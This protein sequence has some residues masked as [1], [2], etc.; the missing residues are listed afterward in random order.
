MSTA[1]PVDSYASFALHGNSTIYLTMNWVDDTGNPIDPDSGTQTLAIKDSHGNII[2]SLASNQITRIS[3]GSY[4]YI[5]VIPVLTA[6][7][8]YCAEWYAS[9]DAYPDTR[10][11][12]FPILA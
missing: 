5:Y 1:V 7:D 3:Q 4:Q 12:F 8:T 6:N 9:I 10:R 11:F 2:Q